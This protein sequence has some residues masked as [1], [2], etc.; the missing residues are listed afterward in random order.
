[1]TSQ[2]L[3][4]LYH[5]CT[6]CNGSG[7]YTEYDDGKASMLAAHYLDVTEKTDKEAW[8]Q[9]FEETRY[10]IECTTCHGTGTK[11]SAEGQEVYQFLQQHA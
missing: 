1:M 11:L 8:A 4:M 2:Q 7:K 3:H 5:T 9:A 6:I 10:M